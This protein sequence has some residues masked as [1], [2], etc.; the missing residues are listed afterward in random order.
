MTKDKRL[1][2]VTTLPSF[3]SAPKYISELGILV[4][5][6]ASDAQLKN[7]HALVVTAVMS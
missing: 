5:L 4:T 7:F 2:V 6:H 3:V 1:H